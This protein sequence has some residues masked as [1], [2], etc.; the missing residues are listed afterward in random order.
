MIRRGGQLVSRHLWEDQYGAGLFSKDSEQILVT[1]PSVY[2][3]SCS[4]LARCFYLGSKFYKQGL[5]LKH[6]TL[7]HCCVSFIIIIIIIIASPSEE[8]GCMFHRPRAVLS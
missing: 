5:F 3:G 1:D 8:L 6:Y 2:S 4:I 7:L